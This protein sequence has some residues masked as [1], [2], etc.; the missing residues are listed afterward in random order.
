MNKNWLELIEKKYGEI[1]NVGEKA[2][3]DALENQHLRFIVEMD[4]NGN[5]YSWYDVAG[6]NSFHASTYNGESIELFEFCME[7]WE[8]NPA[9]ETV[10]EKLREK[11]LYNLYLEERELQDA[12]DYDT[13]EFIL[14]NSSNEQL[15]ECLEECRKDELEFM[16]DEYARSESINKLDTLKEQLSCLHE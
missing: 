14:S 8:N 16:A 13:A 6:G 4:E 3:K 1:I 10:E 12:E 5:V 11:G 9:D 7:Y 15:R 2:Y